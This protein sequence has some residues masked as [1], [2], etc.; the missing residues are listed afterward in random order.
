MKDKASMGSSL[1]LLVGKTLDAV[2]FEHDYVTLQ[3]EELVFAALAKPIFMD[4]D[5]IR[6]GLDESLYRELLLKQ[7]GQ[8]VICISEEDERL[9]IT[10]GNNVTLTVPLDAPT[11]PGPEMATLSSKGKFIAEWSRPPSTWH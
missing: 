4:D 2:L 6:T 9:E 11:P 7:V 5:E 10:L 8:K 3:F 1:D